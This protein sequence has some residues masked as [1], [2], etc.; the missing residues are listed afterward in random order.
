MAPN[1]AIIKQLAFKMGWFVENCNSNPQV[2]I[3]LGSN[4][5]M[6][7]HGYLKLH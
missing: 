4:L 1:F 2:A 7:P 6:Q 3:R 5:V